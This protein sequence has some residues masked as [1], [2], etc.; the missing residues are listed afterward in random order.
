MPKDHCV[1]G[2]EGKV[3][4]EEGPIDQDAIEYARDE[5]NN[6]KGVRHFKYLL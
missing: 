2:Q 4:F 5:A 1:E 6:D 3:D